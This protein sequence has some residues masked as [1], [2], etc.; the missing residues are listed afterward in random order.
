ML[1]VEL[2]VASDIGCLR[3]RNEDAVAASRT[4][5]WLLVADGMG[6]HLGGDVASAIVAGEIEAR[7]NRLLDAGADI[8]AVETG[9]REA[10]E[11]ANSAVFEYSGRDL[12][13]RGMGSTAVVACI[14]DE[15]LLVAH[16]GDSRAYRFRDGKLQQLTHDHSLLQELIDGGMMSPAEAK[17]SPG[18][19]V[20]TRSLGVDASVE[21]DVE[22]FA[23]TAGDIVLLCSDGLTEMVGDEEVCGLLAA[24]WTGL[25]G[26]AKSLIDAALAGG[27]RDNVSIALMRILPAQDV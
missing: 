2:A 16:V 23:V 6:G 11:A 25:D 12:A 17:R 9:L 26:L 18:R 13:L 4:L 5:R 10:V 21:V 19:G 14:V 1:E 27:G 7:L 22:T 8:A 20:L 24:D 3:Q 15:A